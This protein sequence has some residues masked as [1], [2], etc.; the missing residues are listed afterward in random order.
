MCHYKLTLPNVP[1]MVQYAL[2]HWV[3]TAA[4]KI[5]A[6]ASSAEFLI[7]SRDGMNRVRN[8]GL[9]D[10]IGKFGKPNDNQDSFEFFEQHF[11]NFII[12]GNVYWLWDGPHGGM[13]RQVFHLEPERMRVVPGRD[14]TVKRYEYWYQGKV[15]PYSPQE[16]THFKR[17]NPYN[18]YYGLSA[19][20]V[21]YLTMIADTSMLKWNFDFFDDELGLPSGIIVVPAE[22]TNEQ[23]EQYR[24]EFTARHGEG[25]RV[26]F[27][28]SE[29]G[30]AVFMDAGLKHKDYDFEKGRVLNRKAIYE[31]LDLHLGI[32]S[33]NSTEAN[34]I[35]AERRYAE[36][37]RFWHIRTSRKLNSD[38]LEFW[39]NSKKLQTEFEDVTRKAVDW[40]REKE[41]I[42]ADS[43]ILSLDEM[44]MR[45]YKL[46]PLPD[47]VTPVT[48]GAGVAMNNESVI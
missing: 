46:P 31:G 2:N 41:R 39:P 7:L 15:T 27:I 38:G 26:A 47:G 1:Y 44:R 36:T 9:L 35:V 12:A 5:T 33:E 30:S 19:L 11:L 37:A 16:I 45:E 4:N 28:R 21:M 8:H 23:L 34:A 32:M 22:T 42:A 14:R 3:Y 25:R 18:R 6:L 13:P 48:S 29:A 40:R 17:A 10:L 20:Q 24:A 43:T